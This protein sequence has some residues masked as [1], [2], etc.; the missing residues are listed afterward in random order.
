[1]MLILIIYANCGALIHFRKDFSLNDLK[2]KYKIYC[3]FLRKNKKVQKFKHYVF[4]LN[5]AKIFHYVR[6]KEDWQK[7]YQTIHSKSYT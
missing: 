2:D 3:F 6:F 5:T 1:M 7:I 4:D